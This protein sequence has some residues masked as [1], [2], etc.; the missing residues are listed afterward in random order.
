MKKIFYFAIVSALALTS[1]HKDKE[2]IVTPDAPKG[3][4]DVTEALSNTSAQEKLESYA[5]EFVDKFKPEDQKKVISTLKTLA[6][7]FDELGEPEDWSEDTDELIQV[8]KTPVASYANNMAASLTT[9]DYSKAT[10]I[11]DEFFFEFDDFAGVYEEQ[12]DGWNRTDSK[13][14]VFKFKSDGSNCEFKAVKTGSTIQETF[15]DDGDKYKFG[16]PSGVEITLTADGETLLK[17]SAK[18]DY[19]SRESL[20][21]NVTCTVANLSASSET[22]IT[23][24]KISDK[25]TVS[26]DGSTLVFTEFAINGNHFTDVSHFEN[27][28][29]EESQE[30]A[31]KD[32]ITA[33]NG[34]INVMGNVQIT[35]NSNLSDYFANTEAMD[36][37]TAEDAKKFC[38][39]WNKSTIVKFFYSGTDVLQG[40]LK[41]QPYLIDSWTSYRGTKYEEWGT[42][43]IICFENDGSTFAFEDYFNQDKFANTDN[44]VQTLLDKY[45]AYWK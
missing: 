17:T 7:L 40:T 14:I 44:Q 10:E 27:L 21:V 23:N 11:D 34:S 19:K 26:V 13:D 15:N 24:T 45:E 33:M 6:D 31:L 3:K 12:N 30:I 8:K 16:A 41:L 18:A 42:Q 1:C 37:E 9:K 22:S 32:Y 38:D 43:A 28:L 2:D 25:Q 35:C 20:V 4:G 29:T 36:Y 5:T 39:E